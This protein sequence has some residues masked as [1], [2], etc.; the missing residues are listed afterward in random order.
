[1]TGFLATAPGRFL[2]RQSCSWIVWDSTM[3]RLSACMLIRKAA[4]IANL[5]VHDCV[6]AKGSLVNMRLLKKKHA[7]RTG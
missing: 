5:P 2:S 1:M 7:H 4:G 3:K 6:Q